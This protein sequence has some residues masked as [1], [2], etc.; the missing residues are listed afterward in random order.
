MKYV[1]AILILLPGAYAAE[2]K[3][4]RIVTEI[5]Y[6]TAYE[7]ITAEILND[8]STEIK[9]AS[10]SIPSESEIISVK[11]SYGELNYAVQKTRLSF[12]FT[13]PVKPGGW[14]LLFI[15]LKAGGLVEKKDG[16]FEYL[17]VFTPKQNISSFEHVLKLPKGASLYS[18]GKSFQVVEPDAAVSTTEDAPVLLW[19]TELEAEKPSVFLVRFKSSASNLPAYAALIIITFFTTLSLLFVGRALKVR[20]AK[21]KMLRSLKILN[22]RERRVLEEIIKNEGIRQ[23]ELLGKLGYTKA[24]LSKI[25]SKLESRGLVRK[26]KFGKVNRLYPGEKTNS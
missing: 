26:R 19:K 16:Y 2:F 6:I 17:L 3:S 21:M 18:L 25:L 20:Y 10:V 11:D 23:Y 14:R 5:D 13:I 22:E 1:L 7:D 9:S 12:N 24:S 8:G 15:R 4:Y